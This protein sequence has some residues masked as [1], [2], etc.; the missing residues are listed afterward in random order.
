M[1]LASHD[2]DSGRLCWY[3]NYNY[4]YIYIY[5]YIHYFLLLVLPGKVTTATI[6]LLVLVAEPL[7]TITLMI[8]PGNILI[9]IYLYPLKV[10]INDSIKRLSS[11]GGTWQRL[12]E[13][14]GTCSSTLSFRTRCKHQLL[15]KSIRILILTYVLYSLTHIT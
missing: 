8:T 9:C 6:H 14:W 15:S 7:T 5:I 4:N 1:I 3:Y 2:N 10:Q 12:W 13:S 11:K